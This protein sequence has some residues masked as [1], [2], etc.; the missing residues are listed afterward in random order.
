MQRGSIA[1]TRVF[2][3]EAAIRATL[4]A[5][6][7]SLAWLALSCSKDQPV[8][9]LEDERRS[10]SQQLI[11][12]LGS[13]SPER[14]A[15]AALAMGR[16]QSVAYA[17]P[18]AEASRTGERQV[19]LAA[20]FAL[21]QLGL[22][23]GASVPAAAV[24]GAIDALDDPDP[25]IAATAVEALGKLADPRVPSA[26]IPYLKHAAPELRVA[27]AVALFRCRFAP[28]W[29]GDADSP[30]PLPS[31]AVNALLDTMDDEDPS[32]RRA[33]AYAFSRYGQDGAGPRLK[34]LLT[35]E[36]GK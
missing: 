21:G 33:A 17:G 5:A 11:E 32:V 12:A 16:I 29:R 20:L 1:A 27:A 24:T 34:G 15:R 2:G 10:A 4:L 30:P 3:L 14:R 35:D 31:E 19:R 9:R 18:L 36:V 7:F 8:A 25:R 26:V 22:A 28:L 6:L 23:S 13:G